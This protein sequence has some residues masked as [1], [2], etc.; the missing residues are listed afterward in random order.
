M[1]TIAERLQ[2]LQ[3]SISQRNDPG[4]VDEHTEKLYFVQ[5]QGLYHVEFFGSPNGGAYDEFL[6]VICDRE[7]ATQLRSLALRGLDEGANGTRNWNLMKILETPAEFPVLNSIFIEPTSPEHHNQSIIGSG[8]EEEGQIGCLLAKS[9]VLQS[10]TVPSAPDASFFQSG[11]RPLFFLRVESGY[12]HQGFISNLSRCSCF[13]KL[14]MLDFSDFSQRYMENY[15]EACTPFADYECLF[16]S[17]AFTSV[18]RFNL[19]NAVMSSE[20]LAQLRQLRQDLQFFTI[21][22]FGEYV[23]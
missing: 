20:Q 21:Q 12:D 2:S 17:A 11:T 9:P 10:L 14:K 8:Y 1:L 7:V 16:Q 4:W 22:S 13:P 3:H 18:R 6:R 5:S 19:R 15:R 23:R